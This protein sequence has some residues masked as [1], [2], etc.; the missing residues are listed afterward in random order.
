[1]IKTND[2]LRTMFVGDNIEIYENGT[3]IKFFSKDWKTDVEV[4]DEKRLRILHYWTSHNYQYIIDIT[5]NQIYH[6]LIQ[7]SGKRFHLSDGKL[8]FGNKSNWIVTSGL[9][10]ILKQMGPTEKR[11]FFFSPA[12]TSIDQK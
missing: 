5:S 4:V 3:F 9:S 1:M 6:I 7:K 10:P 2:L 12:E 8:Y 11:L